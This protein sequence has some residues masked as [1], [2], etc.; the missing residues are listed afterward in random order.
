MR[1]LLLWLS[2]PPVVAVVGLLIW[3]RP[4]TPAVRDPAGRE[5]PGAVASLEAVELGGW[6]QWI[7]L[8]G[9]SPELPLLLF[10]HGGPG[11]PAMYLAHTFGPGLEND[12]LVV[13]WD[14]RGAGKSYQPELPPETLTDERLL[15]DAEELVVRLRARFGPRPLV[16]VGHSWGS[17]LGAILASRHP[18]WFRAY[19]GIGQV[20]HRR[21]QREAT[22]EFL[23]REARLRHRPEALTALDLQGAAAHETWLFEFGAELHGETGYGPLI[24]AGLFSPEYTFRD[25]LR[26]APG[27]SFSSRHMRR[28]ALSGELM[29][30]VTDLQ[31]PVFFLQGRHDYVTPGE[32][33]E[34]YLERLDAPHKEL[35]WF[36]E[37]AHFPFFEQPARFAEAMRRVLRLT[38]PAPAPRRGT[39]PA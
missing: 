32:L 24:R 9:A 3:D 4:H 28:R 10:L 21:R 29:D 31:V 17:Y 19:V 18:E 36:E 14:Q 33:V 13:H 22:A 27:S 25:V 20:T 12:F 5:V 6:E 30:E 8:R 34:E 15:A 23:R 7:L 11:M 35:I 2:L 1:K 38:P 16:L 26:V 39:P 37:S